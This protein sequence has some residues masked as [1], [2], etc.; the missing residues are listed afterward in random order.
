MHI[1]KSTF[2]GHQNSMS[3][4]LPLGPESPFGPGSPA[5]PLSPF[6]P[7]GPAGPG[8][9]LCP[10]A[11]GKP[12]AAINGHKFSPRPR[13]VKS[14]AFLQGPAKHGHFIVTHSGPVVIQEMDIS[15]PILRK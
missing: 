2:L 15:I 1:G 9:P 11:P 13:R 6:G 3:S 4:C 14:L 12:I 5:E 7:T 8:S 10:T